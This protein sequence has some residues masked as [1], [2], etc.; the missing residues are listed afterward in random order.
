MENSPTS[1]PRIVFY[2]PSVQKQ[3]L[4][5]LFTFGLYDLQWSYENWKRIKQAEASRISPFW[6]TI[7]LFIFIFLLAKRISAAGESAGKNVI[8]YFVTALGFLFLNL[9]ANYD[10]LLA[11][12]STLSI[13]PLA[14][15]QSLANHS[16]KTTGV[17][18]NNTYSKTAKII[19]VI[20]M[21]IYALAILAFLP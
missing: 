2:N 13:I 12:L 7:F 18:P 17:L 4:L 21:I 10:N 20:G 11:L 5:S 3:V 15:L 14:Y 1:I 6:R 8:P 9:F 19:L 16:N